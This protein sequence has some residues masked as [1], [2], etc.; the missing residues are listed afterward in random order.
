VKNLNNDDF[1]VPFDEN[2]EMYFGISMYVDNKRALS[3]GEEF[4][5][6]SNLVTIAYEQYH[7]N[8]GNVALFIIS[9]LFFIVSWL[10]FSVKALQMALF[11]MSHR[12][13]VVDPE[14]TDFYFTSTKFGA[15]FGMI[16]SIVFFIMSLNY[17]ERDVELNIRPKKFG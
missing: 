4:Y 16:A 10:L 3:P 5:H 9:V 1:L 2:G 13:D 14:P 12:L 11:Y 17:L 15:V 6:P 8:Q 7:E